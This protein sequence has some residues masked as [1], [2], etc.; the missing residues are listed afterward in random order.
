[1][2][3][4][5]FR[6]SSC[7]FELS[8]GWSHHAGGQLLVC[9][10]CGE[11]YVLGDGQSCWGVRPGEQLHLLKAEGEEVVRAGVSVPAQVRPV[12]ARET[13]DGVTYLDFPDLPCPRCGGPDALVQTLE[14]WQPCPACTRGAIVNA[15]S[16]IY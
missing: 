7:D 3:G 11:H 4:N 8:S 12:P 14:E 15:G 13:W 2:L 6:C 9:R 16:C 5:V 10:D 1:M